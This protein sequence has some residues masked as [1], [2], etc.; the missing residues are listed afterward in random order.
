MKGTENFK[1][2]IK[3]YLDKEAYANPLF[4]EKYSNPSKNINDCVTF[5][6]NSVQKSGCSGFD[7]QEIYSMAIHYYEEDNIDIGNPMTNAHVVVNHVVELT[8]EEKQKAKDDAIKKA[9]DEAYKAITTKK[10]V[11]KEVIVE[12]GSL[13]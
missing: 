7:D 12:Q 9:Q 5:I 3:D 8:E 6:L 2:T 13:F 11:K 4:G 1:N 10:I